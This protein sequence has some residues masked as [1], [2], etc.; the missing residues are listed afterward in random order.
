MEISMNG[1]LKCLCS[2]YYQVTNVYWYT[3]ARDNI[4]SSHFQSN[5]TQVLICSFTHIDTFTMTMSL[6]TAHYNTSNP[7][8]SQIGYSRATRR[9]PFIFVSGTTALDPNSITPSCPQGVILHADGSAY[10]QAICAFKEAIKAIEALGGKRGDVVRVRM[11]VKSDEETMNMQR[12]EEWGDS[13]SEGERID[14]VGRAMKEM[15]GD[16]KPAATMI[17]GVKFVRPDM[18]VEIELDAVVGDL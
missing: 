16:V 9:G 13:E 15:L 2:T 10:D 17:L 12:S 1:L 4:W 11:Y 3:D 18:K 6:D 5:L 7:Y 8:E 14:G